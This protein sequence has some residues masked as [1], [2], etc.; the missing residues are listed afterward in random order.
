MKKLACILILA[1]G[2]CYDSGGRNL[3][4]EPDGVE[5]PDAVE[6]VVPE[7]LVDVPEE[8]EEPPC[9]YEP[10][11]VRQLADSGHTSDAPH[12]VWNG[13]EVGVVMFEGGGDMI[14]HSYVSLVNV[15]P[16]LSTST[17][18][19]IVG[20]ESHGWGEPAW[21]GS[22][23]GLCWHTDPGMV[24]RTAFRLLDRDGDRIGGRVDLDMQGE[25]CLGLVHGDDRF[26]ASWRH[27]IYTD[28]DPFDVATWVQV[29][30][31]DGTPVGSP[32]ELVAGPYPGV[33]PSLAWT[34]ESFLV[35]YP[36]DGRLSFLWLDPEGEIVNEG[37]APA[38]DAAFCDVA[39]REG[40]IAA[41][42]LT[43]ER[44]ERGLRF[45][46][47]GPGLEPMCGELLL[48][49]DGTGA[50]SPD[51]A[52]VP[53]GWTVSWH[54]GSGEEA[55]AMLLHLDET[56]MP[57]QPRIL[58]YETHNSGYGG[59]TMLSVDGDVFMGIS[60]YPEEHEWLEQVHL[61]RFACTAGEMDVCARQDAE[62]SWGICDDPV[63][64]GWKWTGESCQEVL[65]CDCL[66]EDCDALSRSRWDCLA[67]RF[68]C[69]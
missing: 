35:V 2:G 53:D 21:T 34:G 30:E 52:A 39:E 4:L 16:D 54:V 40:S 7:V 26:L 64:F 22:R 11:G 3:H 68:H 59:P 36:G 42:W 18:P 12:L 57:R 13:S 50:A 20:D 31:A 9:L 38:P 51:V 27:K 25:A 45:R 19:R 6:D 32:L 63:L 67:D 10:A 33:T 17:E 43:G 58:V 29:L 23:L 1:C 55:Y 62:V 5:H 28:D 46:V 41:A 61:H 8:V 56:C 49:E 48:E 24:G 47:F 60:Y 66:G 69:R 44:D 37:E 15:A 14:A 65:G